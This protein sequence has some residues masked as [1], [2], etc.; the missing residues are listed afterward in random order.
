MS[1]PFSDDTMPYWVAVQVC[2]GR[3]QL[4]AAHLGRRGYEVFLPC[5]HEHRRWSD[6]VK[7]V[8]RA[9]FAGYLFCRLGTP[10][11]AKII[12]APGVI[13]IVGDSERPL[14]V[15][16]HEIEAIKRV[17]E[18]RLNAEPW[19]YLETGQC[20]RV[21]CGP[22]RGTD[23]IVLMVKNRHRLVVS[24]SLLQRSVAVE[25]EPAWVSVPPAS[26]IGGS[27][28]PAHEATFTGGRHVGRA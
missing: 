22:L 20:V 23:G 8:E 21:E 24:I 16:T 6:R 18:T 4:S 1:T 7:K 2:A 19:P 28:S 15:P 17:V 3:E 14:P 25:I 10:V 26:R 27:T 11:T 12:T 13:R 5:Y 9:L